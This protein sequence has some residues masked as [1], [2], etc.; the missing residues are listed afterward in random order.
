MDDK[1]SQKKEIERLAFLAKLPTFLNSSLDP[2][3][4]IGIALKHLGSRLE[5]EAATVFL[6]EYFLSDG[7]RIGDQERGKESKQLLFWATHGKP[8]SSL[9]DLRVPANQGIVGWSLNNDESVISNDVDSDQRFFSRID[10]QTEFKTRSLLC[11][12]LRLRDGSRVGAVQVLNKEGGKPFTDLDLEF[13]ASFSS[14]IALALQ[15]AQLYHDLT[16]RNQLLASLNQRKDEMISV[17]THEFRTPLN[18]IQNSVELLTEHQL[19]EEQ[20][21]GIARTV[22]NGINRLTSVV[23]KIR[24]VSL[25]TDEQIKTS[26]SNVDCLLLF[27]SLKA[28]FDPICESRNLS[29]EVT[30]PSDPPKIIVDATLLAICLRNLI[31]NAIR[32]TPNDGNI[33][34]SLDFVENVENMCRI[35]VHDDGIGIAEGDRDLIFEKFYEVGSSLAHSSGTYEFQSGGLGLGLPSVKGILEA[36]GSRIEISSSLGKGSVFSFVLPSVPGTQ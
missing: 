22:T 26:V 7:D 16:Q 10:E 15:N 1:P 14:Q 33:K 32:F 8:P 2:N 34:L 35:G 4:I 36:H 25:L 23:S 13:L 18:I 11:V 21:K 5:A 20:Q 31:S 3:T 29:F 28:E 17:I 6:L 12:P 19:P 27:N 24:D 30:I 9:K